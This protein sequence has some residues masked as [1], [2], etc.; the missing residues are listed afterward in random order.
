MARDLRGFTLALSTQVHFVTEDCGTCGVVFALEY[1]HKEALRSNP[2]RR[3]YCPNGHSMW[4]VG[5]SDEQ[6]LREAEASLQAKD[7]QLRAAIREGDAARR[8]T[9][10]IRQR[11]ANGVCP[12]CTRSFANLRNH[13]ARKHPDFGIEGDWKHETVEFRCSCR[14]TFETFVGLRIHQAAQRTDDWDKP[15]APGY[16]SHLTVV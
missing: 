12:C 15:T 10:R 14:R 9:L 6:K 13:M 3:F 7:D 16:W 5:K 11:I 1:G 2:G 8:E 4:Y